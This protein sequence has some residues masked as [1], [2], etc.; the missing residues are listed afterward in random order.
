MHLN[1]YAGATRLVFTF[2][3]A[4]SLGLY[5]QEAAAPANNSVLTRAQKEDFLLHAKIVKGSQA[6]KGV[7]NTFHAT[8]SDGKITTTPASSA[9]TIASVTSRAPMGPR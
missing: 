6:G 7:T 4:A 1:R 9:S 5:A 2:L 3:A 8:L